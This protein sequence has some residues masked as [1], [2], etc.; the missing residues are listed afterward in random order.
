[1]TKRRIVGF[2]AW[3][4]VTLGA[5]ILA[6]TGSL[7]PGT[8]ALT[9]MLVAVSIAY[10]PA[11][12]IALYRK[13]REDPIE[14][15]ILPLRVCMVITGLITFG[16]VLAYA[17]GWDHVLLA[18]L[19]FFGGIILMSWSAAVFSDGYQALWL[20]ALIFHG[21]LAPPEPDWVK[22]KR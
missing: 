5:I 13:D 15:R 20:D 19:G 10:G 4:I 12:A 22:Y 6:A 11:R 1:M 9:L 16:P 14:P 8:I 17:L 18:G 3:A 21:S 7:A 2:G